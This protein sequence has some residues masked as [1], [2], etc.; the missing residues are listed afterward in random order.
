[1][2]GSGGS[3]Y[4]GNSSLISGGGTT[5]HMTCYSCTTS[6]VDST[7]TNS[8]TNVSATATAD[9]SKTGNG[10]ARITYLGTNI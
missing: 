9:Y 6:T 4:I 5:K 1:M 10:Y 2:A 3:G 7:R 8:N